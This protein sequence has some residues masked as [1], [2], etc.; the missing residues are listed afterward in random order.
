MAAPMATTSSGFTPRDGFLPKKSL[1]VSCTLGIRDIP[2]TSM[3]SCSSLLEMSASLRHDLHGP[4]VRSMSGPT[5]DSNCAR[6]ILR[7]RCFGPVASAVMKGSE[8]SVCARPSS[9]RLAFSATSRRRC[10]ARGSPLR[11]ML[12]SFFEF[13]QKVGKEDFIEVFPSEHSISV[14]RFNF[15]HSTGDLQYGNVERTP[16]KIKNHDKLPVFLVHSVS[17]RGRRRLVNNPQHI[18]TRNLAGVL[19]G[20]SLAVVEI[21]RHGHDCLGDVTSEETLRGLLHLSQHHAP[22]L[23]G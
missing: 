7:D 3:T 5:M 18:Q 6:E 9:S 12:D 22:D 11:S 14:G 8:T 1:T 13:L 16:S 23:T 21:G 15:K 10:I 20:L 4:I 2:P 17:E 19:G